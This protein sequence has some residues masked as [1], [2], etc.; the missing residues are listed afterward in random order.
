MAK[1]SKILPKTP[2]NSDKTRKVNYYYE[3]TEIPQ[4][5]GCIYT[6][7]IDKS[8]KNTVKCPK[9]GTIIVVLDPTCLF[10]ECC[11]CNNHF[12]W[13]CGSVISKS[14]ENRLKFGRKKL[15]D[16]RNN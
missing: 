2:K 15:K 6:I 11:I 8:L 3:Q 16:D 13:R 14:I 12:Q 10:V 1:N 5:M 7:G 9:C 4:Y